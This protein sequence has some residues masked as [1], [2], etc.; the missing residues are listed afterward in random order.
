MNRSLQI[1]IKDE[2]QN[3]FDHFCACFNLRIV[4]S[5]LDGKELE[6]G[7]HY[8]NSQFCCLLQRYIYCEDKCLT[9]NEKMR[10][11]AEQAERMVCY[12]CHG[13]LIEAIYPIFIEQQ[14]M[15]FAMLG[16]IRSSKTLLSELRDQWPANRDPAE[17]E[18]AFS[19]VPFYSNIVVRHILGLVSLLI[20]YAISK[21]VITAKGNLVLAKIVSYLEQHADAP[22]VPL[23]GVAQYV[24]KSPSTIS[25]LVKKSLGISF[26]HL[27]VDTKLNKAEEYFRTVP[28][29]TVGEV[30]ER[31]GYTDQFYFSRIYKKYRKMSPSSYGRR[32]DFTNNHD[33]SKRSRGRQNRPWPTVQQNESSIF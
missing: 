19:S 25:H 23:K 32:H 18:R 10:R 14:I 33:N 5:S 1:I 2:L 31:L 27:Q 6:I 13:G 29:I 21:E 22:H 17:L 20:D 11:E 16:W 26:K 30:S 15:G 12:T 8:P 4:F 9:L 28:G 7:A 3:I 24:G